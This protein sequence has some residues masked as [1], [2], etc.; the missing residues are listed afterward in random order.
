MGAVLEA[1]EVTK[2][3]RDT[4]AL[5]RVDLSVS[6]GET[7]ALIGS[8]GSGKSTLLKLFLGLRRPTGG[9]IRFRGRGLDSLDLMALRLRV[10][11]VIQ[12]GGLFPHLTA[13]QNIVLMARYSGREKEWITGRLNQLTEL[14]RF[15][16]RLLDHYPKQLSGGERQR[17]ALMRALMLE[18]EVLLLDEPL[19]ALDS[20]VRH[21]LQ[22]EL[23]RIFA[24]LGITVVLVTHDIAEAGFLASRLALMSEG[25]IVQE[26]SLSDLVNAP[27]T[28]FVSE[29]VGAQRG[30]M[31]VLPANSEGRKSS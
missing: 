15:S 2:A 18:P 28:Q 25:R 6:E 27:A 3:Y 14:T 20:I 9:E 24:A 12:E 29:F 19:G 22:V 31:D 13:E 30:L 21:D 10:G 11:Y 26:G 1:K 17:V 16:A 4:R 23:K 5:N 7:V 8:S